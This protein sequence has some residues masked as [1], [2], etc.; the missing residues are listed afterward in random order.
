MTTKHWHNIIRWGSDHKTLAQYNSTLFVET[1][2]QALQAKSKHKSKTDFVIRCEAVRCQQ[3]GTFGL[4]GLQIQ[5][6]ITKPPRYLYLLTGQL[7]LGRF[8]Q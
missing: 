2:H 3:L 6:F 5:G 8:G 4:D 1:R 7:K